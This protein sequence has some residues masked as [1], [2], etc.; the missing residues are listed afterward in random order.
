MC[1]SPCKSCKKRFPN[2]HSTCQEYIDWSQEQRAATK[3]LQKRNF[4]EMPNSFFNRKM[5]VRVYGF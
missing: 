1:V 3:A 5:R 2:C 4:E